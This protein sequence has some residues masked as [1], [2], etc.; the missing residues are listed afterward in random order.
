V[1]WG[2]EWPDRNHQPQCDSIRFEA[3]GTRQRLTQFKTG[4]S[5]RSTTPIPRASGRATLSTPSP[6]QSLWACHLYHCIS[7]LHFA[8]RLR[9]SARALSTSPHSCIVFESPDSLPMSMTAPRSFGSQFPHRTA[10]NGSIRLNGAGQG[11]Q[12]SQDW[13]LSRT[14]FSQSNAVWGISWACV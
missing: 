4:T 1:A 12:R 13:E 7:Q 9:V 10:S 2:A 11:G 5:V 14:C 3:I 8:L 6:S